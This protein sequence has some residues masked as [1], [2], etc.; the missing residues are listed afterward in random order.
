M[1]FKKILALAAVAL[2]PALSLAQ[3]EQ[4]DG[5]PSARNAWVL[6][7]KKSG[8]DMQYVNQ[9]TIRQVSPERLTAWVRTVYGEPREE[10]GGDSF[11]G[12]YAYSVLLSEYDCATKSVALQREMHFGP[13][14]TKGVT[15]KGDGVHKPVRPQSLEEA[16]LKAVCQAATAIGAQ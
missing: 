10:Q 5:L 16:S 4:G 12:K 2:S 9:L 15:R 1:P 13:E 14:G 11:V 8:G 3:S 6:T 7:A